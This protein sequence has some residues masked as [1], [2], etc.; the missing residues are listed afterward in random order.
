M[1]SCE[2][3]SP[4]ERAFAVVT[5]PFSFDP[6][7]TT[8]PSGSL[9]LPAVSTSTASPSFSLLESNVLVTFTGKAP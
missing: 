7:G 2:S 3:E 8:V 1:V 9:K 6:F 4:L 5:C